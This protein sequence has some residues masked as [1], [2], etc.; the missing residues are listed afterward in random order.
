M[1]RL[2][3]PNK[4]ILPGDTPS[5]KHAAAAGISPLTQL[6]NLSTYNASV[7]LQQATQT[8]SP[9]THPQTTQTIYPSTQPRTV[10]TEQPTPSPQVGSNFCRYNA[11]SGFPLEVTSH[12]CILLSSTNVVSMVGSST[13]IIN[14]SLSQLSL[15]TMASIPLVVRGRLL[16]HSALQFAGCSL[17]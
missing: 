2:M 11:C 15:R 14:N 1:T 5:P 9:H 17:P 8:T 6:Q 16:Y 13:E 12:L 3:S 7:M 4:D 10:Q